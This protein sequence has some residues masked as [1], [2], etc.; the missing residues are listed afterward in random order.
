MSGRPTR[1]TVTAKTI[2]VVSDEEDD[3][4]ILLAHCFGVWPS[5]EWLC[6]ITGMLAKG[7]FK[8]GR[9]EQNVTDGLKVQCC[10]ERLHTTYFQK[11]SHSF[12]SCKFFSV[13]EHFCCT[14][15]Y[16]NYF[17]L[18]RILVLISVSREEEAFGGSHRDLLPCFCLLFCSFARHSLES[19][20]GI[21][22]ILKDHSRDFSLVF[23]LW[24]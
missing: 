13:N 17:F 2:Q 24:V 1:L 10:R 14:A 12:L 18:S 4:F 20:P 11:K 21:S 8:R 7:E 16:S 3:N 6:R 9:E 5:Q 23:F 19:L 15:S 22:K